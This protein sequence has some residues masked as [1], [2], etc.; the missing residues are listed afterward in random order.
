MRQIVLNLDDE[1]F[2]PFMGM[3]GLCPQVEVVGTSDMAEPRSLID[4][5]MAEAIVEVCNDRTV[6]KH[7]SDL[8]YIMI[9]TNDGAIKDF[10]Y[11][12]TVD[13]FTGYLVQIGI[14][15][16]KIP[17]RSTVYNKVN[18][19]IGKFPEWTFVGDVK[20]KEALRRKNVFTRFSSAYF[21]IKRQ[22][23]DGFLDK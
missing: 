18:D 21:R 20:P 6:Y 22:K 12:L 15:E 3:L 13:D 8:A 14:D 11:F 2:E 10:D 1:A 16:D 19:T 5:C 17:G 7:P 9:G 23:M 4:Q